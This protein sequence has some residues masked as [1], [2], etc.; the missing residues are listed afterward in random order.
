ML[1]AE[2]TDVSDTLVL[3]IKSAY[4]AKELKK[5]IRTFVYSRLGNGSLTVTDEVE[6][7]E[8][9]AFGTALVTLGEWKEQEPG[10]LLVS[11]S[12]ETVLIDIKTGGAEFDVKTE[13]I[14]ED[15]RTKKMPTRIGINLRKPVT[16][17]SVTLEIR[18]E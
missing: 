2:F 1:K 4:A 6:F 12:G 3:D 16:R 15:A 17:A 14:K 13:E 8:P 11:D 7:S 9:Q 5:L 18:H 10:K